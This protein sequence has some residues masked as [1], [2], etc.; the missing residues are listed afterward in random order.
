MLLRDHILDKKAIDMEGREMEVVYD[1][2]LVLKNNKLYVSEV[3]LS[4]YGLLRRMGLTKLANYI[5]NLAESIREQ[6]ISW[7]YIQPLPEDISSFRGNVQFKLL[8]EK[9]ADL[10][11]VDLAD[12]L[13]EMDSDQ[14]VEIFK[15]LDPEHASD[16]LEEIDPSVQRD[17]VESLK[18][19][20][21]AQLVDQMTTGQAADVLS[22]LSA[23][24]ANEILKLLDPENAQKI[25]AIMEHHEEN[26]L[27][28]AT[29][30]Y[31]AFLPDYTVQKAQEEYRTAAKGKDV[32]MYVYVIDKENRLLGVI[33]IKELLLTDDK[34]ILKNIM[35][36]H[37]HTLDPDSTLKEA[38]EMFARYDYRAIPITDDH[39]KMLGV[40]TSRDVVGLKHRFVE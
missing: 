38:Y 12:I 18:I 5:Y 17:L 39:D 9:L 22:I 40:V 25:R 29:Q 23:S 24:E 11:P 14:R 10:H 21:V 32:V 36:E 2:K 8:K 37:V 7:T 3:D 13:E 1:V 16:T 19:E 31:V 30:D 33:N 20:K 15:G 27:D 35:E 34:A 6:T 28:F 4:R 26:I